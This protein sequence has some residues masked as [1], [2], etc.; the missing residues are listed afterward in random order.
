MEGDT[1]EG[2]SAREELSRSTGRRQ[3]KGSRAPGLCWRQKGKRNC[4][5]AVSA[6]NRGEPHRLLV[7]P[8]YILNNKKT[9]A[10]AAR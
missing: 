9:Q 2:D 8:K 6:E 5:A 7:L 10:L 1:R 3:E 4:S